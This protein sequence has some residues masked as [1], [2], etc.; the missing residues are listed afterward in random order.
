MRPDPDET[1]VGEL[2]ANGGSSPVHSRSASG[3]D[4][5]AILDLDVGPNT[6][7][8]GAD[9]AERSLPSLRRG[10]LPGDLDRCG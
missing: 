10:H 2:T 5:E 1:K 7:R 4:G 3:H 9:D 8:L 6:T